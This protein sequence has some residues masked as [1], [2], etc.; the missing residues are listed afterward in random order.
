MFQFLWNRKKYA[1]FFLLED[2]GRWYVGIDYLSRKYSVL[3]CEYLFSLFPFTH[4]VLL[5]SYNCTNK[6]KVLNYISLSFISNELI[7]VLYWLTPLPLDFS[8]HN[9]WFNGNSIMY[10]F[11]CC[12]R[13]VMLQSISNRNTNLQHN[14]KNISSLST[15]CSSYFPWYAKG[16]WN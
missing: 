12:R 4:N 14:T 1:T 5:F 10:H 7:C 11:C 15:W 6:T 8:Q 2:P 3:R 16:N 13:S 9:W